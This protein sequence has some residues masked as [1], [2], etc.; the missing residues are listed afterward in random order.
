MIQRRRIIFAVLGL[1]LVLLLI[2]GFSHSILIV[3][4]DNSAS[5]SVNLGISGA[6]EVQTELAVG[7]KKV[8]LVKSGRYD[9]EASS[10][11]KK[12]L[13]NTNIRPFWI[14]SVT[15]DFKERQPLAMLG[16]GSE[17]CSLDSK[18]LGNVYYFNCVDPVA[19]RALI[20][21]DG[22]TIVELPIAADA[23]SERTV[24]EALPYLGELGFV[25]Q[26]TSG[27]KFFT[28]GNPQAVLNLPRVDV[29]GGGRLLA[30]DS[31]NPRNSR[32]A[33]L[34]GNT[35]HIYDGIAD[36][37]P[38]TLDLSKYYGDSEHLHDIVTLYDNE[39]YIYSSLGR[40][41]EQ[42]GNVQ[43]DSFLI[44]ID[45]T[46]TSDIQQF[47]LNKSLSFVDVVAG[48]SPI[49]V[50][51]VPGEG[52]LT[53]VHIFQE[54]KLEPLALPQDVGDDVCY[55]D[56]DSLYFVANNTDLYKYDFSKGTSYFIYGS[57]PNGINNIQSAFGQ[58]NIT[59]NLSRDSSDYVYFSSA[60]PP[61]QENNLQTVL[62]IGSDSINDI[63]RAYAF[64]NDVLVRLINKAAYENRNNPNYRPT[65][66]NQA[67]DEKRILNLLRKKGVQI[68]EYKFN[69]SY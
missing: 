20:T 39:I 17:K 34:A 31:S 53:R 8:M 37:Q 43:T 54:S 32:L 5:T 41:S 49:L 60:A 27:A 66:A 7:G 59:V 36:T 38:Q 23:R 15:L 52:D 3:S 30:T 12:T 58:C 16:V 19:P 14:N 2:Y 62:P 28:S 45:A 61:G 50:E 10:G 57:N 22:K 40:S 26:T 21:K 1:L 24:A 44:K 9:I 11:D 18:T 35:L 68:E 29:G 51:R 4:S 65:A 6:S 48:E 42:D 25:Y 46:N 56:A 13:I 33:L 64:R 63:R 55:T 47:G 69:F 67:E